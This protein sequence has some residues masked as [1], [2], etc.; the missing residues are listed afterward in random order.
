MNRTDKNIID[1]I[2]TRLFHST[3]RQA[4]F[5][6]KLVWHHQSGKRK[7]VSHCG[8]IKEAL[9]EI[10]RHSCIPMD[11]PSHNRMHETNPSPSNRQTTTLTHK[12]INSVARAEILTA[13]GIPINTPP[14]T[15]INI[16]MN[17]GC[18]YESI[19][20]TKPRQ[21]YCGNIGAL[22]TPSTTNCG[23]LFFILGI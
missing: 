16:T 23:D 3:N 2:K 13:Y 17:S 7:N 18:V 20:G 12:Y 19:R 9:D 4:P 14:T 5:P 8:N 15:P 21:N 6:Q 22:H 11:E 1:R 10:K